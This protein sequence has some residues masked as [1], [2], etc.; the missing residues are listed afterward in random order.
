MIRNFVY[1][2]DNKTDKIQETQI[3]KIRYES[4]DIIIDLKVKNTKMS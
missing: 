3:T 2:K 1:E 4:V